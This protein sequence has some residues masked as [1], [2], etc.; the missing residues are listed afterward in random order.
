VSGEP[1]CPLKSVVLALHDEQI[2]EHGGLEGLRDEGLLDSALAR[3]R[4]AFAYGDPTLFEMAAALAAGICKNH[5]FLDGNKRTSLVA[6]EL[7]LQLNGFDLAASDPEIVSVWTRL[8]ES[9]ITEAELSRWL[10]LRC[11]P[12]LH[13]V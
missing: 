2:A 13:V 9:S 11:T 8:A 4:H 6:A 1:V 3:P 12:S 7:L 10:E 5:P